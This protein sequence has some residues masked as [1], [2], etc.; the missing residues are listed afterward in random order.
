[1]RKLWFF[2]FFFYLS[3]TANAQVK[4]IFDTDIGGDA[5]DLGALVMLHNF[6]QRGECELLAV[7]CWSTEKYSV[8][9][10]DAVNRFYNHPDIPIGVRKE[11]VHVNHWNY[12]K[13]IADKFD[14]ELT[15]ESAHETT[16][17]YRKILS[18]S[19]DSSIVLVTVGPLKNLQ[20]LINSSQ[21]KW[22]P[23]TG[24]ELLHKK[25]KEISMMG[26][27]FPAGENEWNFNGD[28]PGVTKYVLENIEIPITFSG[29][30]VGVAIKTGKVFNKLDKNTPLYIGFNYFSEHAPWI[31]SAFKGEVLDNSTFDQTSVLYAVKGGIGTYWDRIDGGVCEA[32]DH[33]GNVWISPAKSNHSYLKLLN[34]EKELEIIIETIML[35]NFD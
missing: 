24:K 3:F 34:N 25:V 21:D 28:M 35:N 2:A 30:E 10:I 5:D 11:G 22:S 13:S 12:G 27:K 4:I 6:M 33:G 14:Y 17:L 1:M 16:D 9:A 26:G 29:F 23:L 8:P 20:N 32:D 18:Q 31:K 7:M 19:V 15:Y